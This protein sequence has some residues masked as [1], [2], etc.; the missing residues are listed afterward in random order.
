MI[1]GYKGLASSPKKGA[2]EGKTGFIP[3]TDIPGAPSFTDLLA[4]EA[5]APNL[6]KGER[7]RRRIL[8]ATALE[9]AATPF[10][11]LSMDQIARAADVS[12]PALYEYFAS[13]EDAARAVLTDFHARTLI[14]PPQATR[15]TDTLT[16]IRRTNRYYIDYFAKNA[17]FMERVRE[18]RTTMP[19]LIAEKQRVNRAWAERIAGHVRRRRASALA[20]PALQLRIHF[21]ECMIDDV[22]REIFVIE[23]P[24]LCALATNLDA[25]AEELSIVWLNAL[26]A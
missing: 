14:I 26:Y 17:V 7:T 3:G 23:N 25:L 8:L 15:Q 10:A 16:A 20:E 1:P 6:R 22:L 18:L 12:R 13:K 21:L 19:E 9:L 24:D 4:L 11:A 5:G 2:A